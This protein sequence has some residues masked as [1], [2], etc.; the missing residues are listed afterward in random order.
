M[1]VFNKFRTRTVVGVV[2]AVTMSVSALGAGSASAGSLPCTART[3]AKYFAPW[4]DNNQYFQMPDGGFESGGSGWTFS[5]G[6]KGTTENE[7]WK[8][9]GSGDS[10]SLWIPAG[11]K[12]V[13]PTFCVATAEDS[14]RAFVKRPG[15]ANASLRLH[16]EVTSGVNRATSDIDINGSTA[17]WTVIDRLMLP[18]IRDSSGKQYVSVWFWT[19]GV[20]ASWKVDDVM[21]DPWK[22]M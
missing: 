15:V 1:S 5:G 13:S 20:G 14:L 16:V 22:T 21:I 9:V 19:T 17:G 4:G 8:I 10:K 11:A 2:A 6:A 18:D 7:P 3:T 12:A